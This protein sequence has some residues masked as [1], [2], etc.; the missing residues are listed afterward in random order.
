MTNIMS[1]NN[2]ITDS[3]IVRKLQ[4]STLQRGLVNNT[5][6]PSP[7]SNIDLK[8]KNFFKLKCFTILFRNIYNFL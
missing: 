7:H 1:V 8:N 2:F 4:G 3:T 6:S 5:L